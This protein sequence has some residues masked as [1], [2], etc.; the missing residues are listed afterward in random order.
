MTPSG[1]DKLGGANA[2]PIRLVMVATALALA[3]IASMGWYVW[4]SVQVLRQVEDRTFRLLELTGQISYLNEAVQSSARLN[5]TTGDARWLDRYETMLAQRKAALAEFRSIAPDI[6]DGKAA[7]D[8]RSAYESHL[9]IEARAFSLAARGQREQAAALLHSPDY[10]AL[11][12][13]SVDATAQIQKELRSNAQ[14][15]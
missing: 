15:A 2:L 8:L 5:A 13:S 1:A 6:Y 9:A 14:A 7:T 11:Q 10:D 12:R 4:N 3:L